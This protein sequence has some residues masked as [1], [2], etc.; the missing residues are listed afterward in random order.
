MAPVA[1]PPG[2]PRE[3][4]GRGSDTPWPVPPWPLGHAV[5]DVLTPLCLLVWVLVGEDG[6][7]AAASEGPARAGE[8]L[9][10]SITSIHLGKGSDVRA[11][12]ALTW[13]Q[14]HAGR[15]VA[16]CQFLP[17][18]TPKHG[19]NPGS[20]AVLPRPRQQTRP[21]GQVYLSNVYLL[22]ARKK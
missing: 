17:K 18:D 14:G 15:P 11:P 8:L 3:R 10:R 9:A 7:H 4:G 5:R 19:E 13:S 12:E 20:S 21:P 2:V 1:C 16:G 6:L 22:S